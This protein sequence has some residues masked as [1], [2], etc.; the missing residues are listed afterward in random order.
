MIRA[1]LW[2]WLSCLGLFAQDLL[3]SLSNGN[4]ISACTPGQDDCRDLVTN[5]LGGLAKPQ[6]MTLG[7]DERLYVSSGD[8]HQILRYE[9]DGRFVDVFVDTS[10]G[11]L[12]QPRGLVFG[13]DGSLYVASSGSHAIL[14]Y[15][16][17]NGTFLDGFVPANS[18]G[19]ES[20]VSLTF[21]SDN[22]LY[23]LSET[24]AN[25]LRYNG[26]DGQFMD[27]LLPPGSGGLE[28]PGWVGFGPDGFLYI[29]DF[30]RHQVLRF[31]PATGILWD[32]FAEEGLARPAGACFDT[33]GNLYVAS[34]SNNQVRVYSTAGNLTESFAVA[35]AP[36]SV[37]CPIL[38]KPSTAATLLYPWISNNEGFESILVAHNYSTMPAQFRLS[39]RRAQGPPEIVERMV[40]A[41]GFLRESAD[42]LFPI[43]G[44]GSGYSVLL[45]SSIPQVGGVWVTNNLTTPSGSSPSQGVAIEL[46]KGTE[47]TSLRWGNRIAYGFLPTTEGLISAPVVVN[48]GPANAQV[49][50][51][52]Y[53]ASGT[54]ILEDRNTL[55][56]LPPLRPFAAVANQ[57]V[58][59]DSGDVFVIA[60]SES[61]P[62]TGVSFVFNSDAEPAIGNVTAVDDRF[63]PED[64]K[65]QWL[66]DHAIPITSISPED[67]DFS[68]GRRTNC[69]S[70]GRL[71]STKPAP[72]STTSI[73]S[74]VMWLRAC[75]TSSTT[76]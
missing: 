3:V 60:I 63:T 36:N 44:N 65:T 75:S 57:L 15:D 48:L 66:Q 74:S 34:F 28:R 72:S 51:Q 71:P 24:R 26:S 52:F 33:S 67:E 17:S 7:P 76:S 8:S 1:A 70:S 20:P 68:D 5:G 73:R 55:A 10:N 14:R 38:E 25:L 35:G 23:V 30:N 4:K 40:P 56:D 69:G 50:L 9:P 41:N 22:H 6:A 27:E 11:G 64:Q 62:I 2:L 43:L 49:T 29:T 59:S 21:G 53:D 46:P 54:L 32:T 58:P 19:L 47:H 39:A 31:D 61:H 37:L 16:G 18:G 12:D 13:P 42:E 45:E